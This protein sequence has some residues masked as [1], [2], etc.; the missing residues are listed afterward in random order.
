MDNTEISYT[1]LLAMAWLAFRT[2]DTIIPSKSEQHER[3]NPSK[4]KEQISERFS[5]FT[6]GSFAGFMCWLFACSA[7]INFIGLAFSYIEF[8]IFH[9]ISLTGVNIR[10]PP[11]GFIG[12][13]PIYI[14]YAPSFFQWSGTNDIIGVILCVAGLELRDWSRR[15][16]GKFFTL[17]LNVRKDQYIVNTGPYRFVRHPSYTG[18]VVVGF[19]T[20]YL[21]IVPTFQELHGTAYAKYYPT[22]HDTNV[23]HTIGLIMGM[24]GQ[25]AL[26]V[27]L[28]V[29]RI[30]QEEKMLNERFGN[31]WNQFAATRAKIIPYVY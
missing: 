17:S 31:E 22:T 15:E 28:L 30:P 10:P 6:S 24:M 12:V 4:E 3:Q 9:L 25:L 23:C 18:A 7:F 8:A 21:I 14:P 29:I 11:Y 27:I 16:L 2:C 5:M 19:Y 20:V 1:K 26:I 13:L